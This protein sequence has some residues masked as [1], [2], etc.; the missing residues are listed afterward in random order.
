MGYPFFVGIQGDG[1]LMRIIVIVHNTLFVFHNYGFLPP[2]GGELYDG[3]G[4]GMGDSEEREGT[5]LFTKFSRL[6]ERMNRRE[7]YRGISNEAL[8]KKLRYYKIKKLIE[9]AVSA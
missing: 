2:P 6:V 4:G 1:K 3:T 8:E 5:V 7:Y 9:M